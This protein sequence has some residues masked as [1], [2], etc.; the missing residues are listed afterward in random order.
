MIDLNNPEF[1]KTDPTVNIFN[2]GKAGE[3]LVTFT[4]VKKEGTNYWSVVFKEDNDLKRELDERFYPVDSSDPKKQAKI[5]ILGRRL[6]HILKELGVEVL[7]KADTSEELIDKCMAVIQEKAGRVVKI[8]VTF[9]TVKWPNKRG[10]LQ[11]KNTFPFIRGDIKES[12][13]FN[14]SYDLMTR[15]Q[16]QGDRSSSSTE[17]EPR[18]MRIDDKAPWEVH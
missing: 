13:P 5:N 15:P 14:A 4:T 6:T 11:L 17:G 12:I 1:G 3:V 9:G 10:F 7:P 16:P 18:Q 2:N 8:G